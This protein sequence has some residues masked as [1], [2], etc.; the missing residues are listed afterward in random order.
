MNLVMSGFSF[1]VDSQGGGS[2][3]D[4]SLVIIVF[5]RVI[6]GPHSCSIAY[7]VESVLDFQR[8]PGVTWHFPGGS[9]PHVPSP[10]SGFSQNGTLWHNGFLG[11]FRFLVCDVLLCFVTFPYISC[12]SCGTWFYRFLILPSTLLCYQC[13]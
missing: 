2:G 11:S 3:P 8:R 10:H 5:H 4:N 1:F 7:R 6:C 9:R 12:V 13:L